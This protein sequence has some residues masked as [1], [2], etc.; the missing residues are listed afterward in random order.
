LSTATS[1][2]ARERDFY[3]AYASSIR[4]EP[5][6]TDL[7]VRWLAGERRPWNSYWQ[8]YDR[9]LG[10]S[11]GLA[12][13]VLEI[14]CGVGMSAIQ[15]ARAGRHIQ[16]FDISEG[17][18]AV[19]RERAEAL[20]LANLVDLRVASATDLPYP[21]ASFDLIFGVD[22]LHHVPLAGTMKEVRR[23][24]RPGGVAYFREPLDVPLFDRLRNTRLGRWL[25]PKQ[26]GLAHHITEDERKL[27][28]ADIDLIRGF[29]P[30]LRIERSL[31]FARFARILPV[32]DAAAQRLDRRLMRIMPFLA[33]FGGAGVIELRQ[34]APLGPPIGTHH[35]H[36][37]NA[38]GRE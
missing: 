21:D 33:R 5:V 32:G 13:P 12:G 24:L 17:S 6:S 26:V 11:A 15:L 36:A 28:R 4:D 31:V 30:D 8:I 37:N 10:A 25:A 27:D 1:R 34:G 22:I 38:N 9:V 19:A 20:G 29:F 2:E 23:L 18:V 16:G 35:R 3:N 7:A 14:G